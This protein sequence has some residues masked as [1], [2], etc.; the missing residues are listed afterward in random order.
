[1]RRRP[2]RLQIAA[3]LVAVAATVVLAA[4]LVALLQPKSPPP[5]ATEGSLPP[6]VVGPFQT[7]PPEHGVPAT[8]E[9]VV[10]AAGIDIRVVEGNGITIPLHI[11]LHYPGTAEPGGGSNAVFYAHDQVGMFLG[12]HRL[13]LGDQIRAVRV[14]GTE[15]RYRVSGIWVVPFDDDAVLTATSFEEITLLTCTTYRRYDPRFIVIGTPV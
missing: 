2:S 10:P 12:L 9:L 3:I 4:G 15:V 8:V 7:S 6:L 14:D 5:P 1:M 11:A 13:H